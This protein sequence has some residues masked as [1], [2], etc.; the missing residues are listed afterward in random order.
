MIDF[1]LATTARWDTA[2]RRLLTQLRG[3]GSTGADDDAE[4]FDDVEVVQ[5]LGLRANPVLRATLEVLAVVMGDERLGLYLR[6]KSRQTGGIEPE[7]GGVVVHSLGA[8][9]SHVYFRANGDIEVTATAG[10]NVT[11][12][13]SGGGVI[14]LNT[15]GGA[16]VNR[17]GDG[18]T[19]SVDMGTWMGQVEVGLNGLAP[20]AVT[21]F[22]GA[23][24]AT[25]D[26]NS[27]VKA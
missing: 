2:A 19:R 5:P 21:P 16:N 23:I 22:A 27:A 6:D 14:R 4:A 12:T 20:G 18:V 9:G 1:L 25:A 10:R 17:A 8:E 26:G 7:A 13:T 3:A 15:G 24:G 11:V